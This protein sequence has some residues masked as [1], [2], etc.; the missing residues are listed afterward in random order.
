MAID[1]EEK[2]RLFEMRLKAI[3][4][5]VRLRILVEVSARPM[6]VKEIAKRVG[7]SQSACSAHLAVL[8]QAG[9]LD[10]EKHGKEVYY[11][12]NKENFLA[13][14]REARELLNIKEK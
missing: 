10:R 1:T 2:L 14:Q 3:S 4:N 13:H 11:S 5:L 9:F 7:L 6:P 8:W 12:L